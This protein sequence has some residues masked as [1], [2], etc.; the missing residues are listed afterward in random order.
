M[1]S[2][3]NNDNAENAPLWAA[4]TVNQAPTLGNVAENLFNNTTQD[5]VIEGE[6]I[7]LFGVDRAEAQYNHNKG[8]HT[9]WVLRKVGSGGRAGRI[10]QEVLVAMNTIQGDSDGSTYDD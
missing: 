9:G 2:W 3:G 10:Q 8:V 1:S 4:M 5:S 7:G 6:A